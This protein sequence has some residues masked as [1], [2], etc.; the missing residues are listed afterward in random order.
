MLVNTH[1]AC[2]LPGA[3][4]SGH[5]ASSSMMKAGRDLSPGGT[6]PHLDFY[7]RMFLYMRILTQVNN[8]GI[9]I[10]SFSNSR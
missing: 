1:V 3:P 5:T 8:F 9:H 10:E 6:Q 4:L 7:V 2:S